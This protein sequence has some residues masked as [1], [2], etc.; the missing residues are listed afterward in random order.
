[1]FKNARRAAEMILNHENDSINLISHMDPDGITA[2]AIISKALDRK[3]IRHHVKFVQMLYPETIEE[4]EIGELTIFTDLGSSQLKNLKSKFGNSDVIIADHH[5]PEKEEEWSN[6]IHFNAH[7]ENLDGVEEISGAGMAYLIAKE[8]D[9][10]NKVLSALALIGAIG[11]IQNGWGKLKGFNRKIAQDGIEAGVVKKKKDLLLY[12][13]H[14]KPI[15]QTL[16]NLTDPPIPGISNNTEGCVSMLKD[17]GIPYKTDDGYRRPVDLTKEEKK[18]LATELITRSISSAPE[19]LVEYIPGLIV[20]EVYTILTE[21]ERSLLRDADEFSTC[22]NS[23]ARHEQPLIGLE[24]AKGDRDVYYRQMLKL[25]RYH[26]R[27]I[28][29]GM[30][31]IKE[32]GIETG[33]NGYIQYFDASD[34]LKETFVGTIANLL[35]GQ[36]KADPYK[37]MVGIVKHDDVAKISARCSKLLFL[38]GLDLGQ[39]MKLAAKS[40][41]GDGGGHAVA[42]GAQV[43]REQVSKLLRKFEQLLMEEDPKERKQ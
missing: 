17:L 36:E 22:I 12:G 43:D 20:G 8:L 1:M 39:A 26:R 42:C 4:L 2:A 35:L 13:R 38:K 37:P 18:K 16:K 31:H 28:A 6:L 27:C 24:V 9:P 30:S 32:K 33:P 5:S 21:E 3:E 40:V 19:E 41:G 14:T 29:K 15:F 10:E 7:L 34:V 11:D 23:T 25:L